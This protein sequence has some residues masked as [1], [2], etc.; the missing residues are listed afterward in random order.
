MKLN[1][2]KLILMVL[3]DK[4]FTYWLGKTVEYAINN[5]E[6]N[7]G[8]GASDV[9]LFEVLYGNKNILIKERII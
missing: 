9:L 6:L 7:R 5:Y 4:K 1:K 2:W 8:E 3:T